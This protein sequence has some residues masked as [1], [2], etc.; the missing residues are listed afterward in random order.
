MTIRTLAEVQT[1][2]VSARVPVTGVSA[3]TP[4]RQ[5]PRDDVDPAVREL[6]MRAMHLVLEVVDRRRPPAQLAPIAVPHIIDQLRASVGPRATS[7]TAATLRRVHVQWPR[8]DAAEIFG[9]YQRG[10]R[11]QAIAG[12]IER[13]PV[14]LPTV[15]GR[16]RRTELRWQLVAVNLG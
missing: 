16:P 10:D 7:R 14:R 1:P 6:G 11:V 9:T 12:R 4:M 5:R 3:L 15:D 13:V 8:P 2:R